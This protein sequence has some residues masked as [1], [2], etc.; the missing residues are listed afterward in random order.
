MSIE[1][2]QIKLDTIIKEFP[3]SGFDTIPDGIMTSLHTCA[4][5]A[6]KLEMKSGK[7]VIENLIAKLITRKTGG[8]TDDSVLVRLTALEFYVQKLKDGTAENP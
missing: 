4:G 2:L 8:N 1:E 5:E 6:E 7:E 3:I